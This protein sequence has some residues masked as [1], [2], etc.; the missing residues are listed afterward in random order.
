MAMQLEDWQAQMH[1]CKQ[2]IAKALYFAN[3]KIPCK[4]MPIAIIQLV[5]NIYSSFCYAFSYY[6]VPARLQDY[7]FSCCMVTA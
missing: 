6:M 4:I 5:S 1:D 7:A 2:V 3:T